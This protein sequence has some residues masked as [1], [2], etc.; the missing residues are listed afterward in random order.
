MGENDEDKKWERQGEVKGEE[1]ER[2][3]LARCQLK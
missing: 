3:M 1:G 2:D